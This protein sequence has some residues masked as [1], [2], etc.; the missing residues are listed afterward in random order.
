MPAART[1][2]GTDELSQLL[3][4]LR[5]DVGLSGADAARRA[6]D[7]FS[8]S[9]VSRWESGRLTPSPEDVE[10]YARALGASSRVRRRLV[11]LARDR[12]D[13]HRATTP[14]R[15]G[16]SR[17]AAH[18]QRVLRNES[19]A[20][21]ITVFHPLLIPGALQSEPY[22]RA[23]FSSGDLP[24]DVVEARTA[25]R[26]RR[27]DLLADNERRFTF[28]LTE[29]TLGWRPASSPEVMAAQLE[30]L[31]DVS[32]RSNVRLGV[33][34]W[35]APA[36][37]FPPCGFDVYDSRTVVV[38]VVGGAAYY[39]DPDDVARYLAMLDELEQLAVYDEAM[40]DLLLGLVAEYRRS[41]AN[42]SGDTAG[43]TPDDLHP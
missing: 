41:A 14:A 3:A 42:G 39:N 27:A 8:Q 20:R 40:R 1:R 36:S 21:H 28:L 16:V 18:E 13:Q 35:G 43:L 17:G 33:I 24:P 12:Q 10:R 29:G 19:A 26:L 31:V 25:A 23:V 30:H 4:Q 15:V 9:K 5:D 7:G 11:A 6:G 22:V 34:P 37:V 32:G 2:V 38:G